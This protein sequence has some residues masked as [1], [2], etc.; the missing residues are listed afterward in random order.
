MTPALGGCWAWYLELPTSLLWWGSAQGW[1]QCWGSRVEVRSE[2]LRG[3]SESFQGLHPV[4]PETSG[5]ALFCEPTNS[6]FWVG[7]LT[8]VIDSVLTYLE[9]NSN[10]IYLS[11]SFNLWMSSITS[12]EKFTQIRLGHFQWQG[13]PYQLRSLSHCWGFTTMKVFLN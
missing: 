1:S 6:L 4:L 2:S 9:D 3:S 13:A 7:F 8:F 11:L 5:L 10:I 12:N